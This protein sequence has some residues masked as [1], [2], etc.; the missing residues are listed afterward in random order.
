MV[1]SARQ[2][3]EAAVVTA[4]WDGVVADVPVGLG[5]HLA[6]GAPV[7]RLASTRELMVDVE[8]SSRLINA[9]RPTQAVTIAL[10]TSPVQYQSGDIYSIS[11]VP[12]VRMTHLVRVRLH[13]PTGML[14]SGQPAQVVFH[15]DE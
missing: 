12:S 6:A 10:P 14:L 11:P 13:N 1:N 8:V 5:D 3:V 7:A 4:P 15:D 2:K 9:L